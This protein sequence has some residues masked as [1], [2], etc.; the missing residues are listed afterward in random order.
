M[1]QDFNA[2][3]TSKA[4]LRTKPDKLNSSIASDTNGIFENND[5]ISFSK[6]IFNLNTSNDILIPHRNNVRESF[7]GNIIPSSP[8]SPT[9]RKINNASIIKETSLIE[10]KRDDYQFLS[11]ALGGLKLHSNI[12]DKQVNYD[13]NIN[14]TAD[15]DSILQDIN[16]IDEAL[17]YFAKNGDDAPI[18]FIRL[19]PNPKQKEFDPYDL[20]VWRSYD[21]S[22]E[23]FSMSSSGIVH[24]KPNSSS[25]CTNM[26]EWIRERA[27]FS[28]IRKIPFFRTFLIRKAYSLWLENVKFHLFLKDRKAI[29][30][31]LFICRYSF[32]SSILSCNRYLQQISNILFIG[33]Y[34][35]KALRLSD[36]YFIMSNQ[37]ADT[38]KKAEDIIKHIISNTNKT[39]KKVTDIASQDTSNSNDLDINSKT[40]SLIKRKEAKA[41][42]RDKR[43]K[44][45]ADYLVLPQFIR[46]IDTLVLSTILE[47][48]LSNMQ[49]FYK[50]LENVKKVGVLMT[51]IVFENK[52]I[53]FSPNCEQ[54]L[55]NFDN[56]FNRIIN[57]ISSFARVS[58]N[59]SLKSS[60][61]Q[62]KISTNISIHSIIQDNLQYASIRQHFHKLIIN[63]F[64]SAAEYSIAFENIQPIFDFNMNWNLDSFISSP[65]EIS[66]LKMLLDKI[67]NWLKD[68]ER[69]RNRQIGILEVNSKQLQSEL[70]PL[71]E[72]RL[73]EIKDYIKDAARNQSSSL[74]LTFKDII[75]KL[76]ARPSKLKEF[77]HQ[78]SFVKSI[79][80]TEKATFRKSKEIDQLYLILQQNEVAIAA[81]DSVLHEDLKENLSLY[82]NEI[83]LVREYHMSES[84][85]MFINVESSL[86][87]FQES[88]VKFL[89]DL[90]D[91]KYT[92]ITM[93]EDV[94]TNI[95]GLVQ[96]EENLMK[97]L[98]ENKSLMNYQLLLNL[99]ITEFSDL[100][101]AK[102]I[103]QDTKRLWT[104]IQ[105]WFD[106][107][108]SWDSRSYNDLN[109]D[110][111]EKVVQIY[112]KESY[113]LNKVLK[114]EASIALK[115]MITLFRS[116]LNTIIDF[117]NRNMKSRHYE[118]LFSR[119][120][121]QYLEGLQ[122]N[123][124]QLKE[125]G[126]FEM[127]DLIQEISATATG[128]ADLENSLNKIVL[129]WENT[130]FDV[131]SYRDQKNLFILGS[132][133]DI[134]IQLEDHQVTLQTMLGSRYIKIV[135]EVV[136][137]WEAK[138]RLLSE[139]LDEWV[140]CQKAW[141]Y[142]ENIFSAEDIQKQLPQETQKFIGVDRSWKSMMLR[143]FND[144]LVI[145]CLLPIDNNKNITPL[146][147]FQGNNIVLEQIQK[148]LE[149]YLETKRMAFPRFYFLSND[150]LLEI[151][152]QTRDPHSVQPH[153]SKCFDAIKRI[154]FGE[155]KSS[156]DEINGFS[157]PLE[158][159]VSLVN[160]VKAEGPVENWLRN[161]ERSMRN[162]LFNLAKQAYTNYPP[163]D[164]EAIS[165]T[166][167][168]FNYPA[169][170]VIAVDQIAWTSR[171]S[172]AISQNTIKQF[173]EFSIRQIDFMV[174]LTRA[175][176]SKLQ[177]TL[178]GALLTIDVHARDVTRSLISRN[179]QSLS[180]FEWTKQL[181]YYWDVGVDDI[182]VRQTNTYFRYGYEY[183][184]NSE[185]LVITPLTDICYMTLTGALHMKLGGAPA[186]K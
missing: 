176:L 133:E 35:F 102:Q 70:S 9:K 135:R 132:L 53:M 80:E 33:G 149:D 162:T 4:S 161:F 38:S 138:L 44:A 174:Q 16:T 123:F 18:K 114:S 79:T 43:L 103:L 82:R 99:Q 83:S 31:Q 159:M 51:N 92:S 178:L 137:E 7:I 93:F 41:E 94:S 182:V 172:N 139:T 26:A 125:S 129:A 120:N 141:M 1:P 157:D 75:P 111:I 95:L 107:S 10:S 36:F 52:S 164:E 105:S 5:E 88:I 165:R 62:Y 20:L 46:Y 3:G 19:I 72:L 12:F 32:Q 142:L 54:V 155:S 77:C 57:T 184:G 71:C 181:R 179:T 148:S 28:I 69:L 89:D 134:M 104:T 56:L 183:L 147:L 145:R 14:A 49:S 108:N 2:N 67:T 121:L 78:L 74:L 124:L 169:Q 153:M 90:N 25:D 112:F 140:L 66:E 61:G 84:K 23:H 55:E 58:S 27:T 91:F 177:R 6:N 106:I 24:I 175:D 186:G 37:L 47:T 11:D 22:V 113:N 126:L 76:S 160:V 40:T 85:N 163:T 152:S 150:E 34:D 173:L 116:N 29:L 17:N 154:K 100:E 180:D 143:T 8:K 109:T 101:K 156:R 86:S 117:G 170:V 151:L 96:M 63:N 131:I 119:V 15:I 110:E 185:R 73:Q 65:H 42:F 146:I 97:L 115:D 21:P 136:D 64:Q 87:S 68:L 60:S 30:D 128:E 168:L 171:C 13:I 48:L 50:D 39:I 158:E 144:P 127:K 59:V 81:D 98:E 167:W 118:I 45:R 122:C 166:E 130:N